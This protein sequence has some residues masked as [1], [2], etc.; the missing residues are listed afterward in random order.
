ML[1]C[2]NIF[3]AVFIPSKILHDALILSNEVENISFLRE[4]A[5]VAFR[6]LFDD[7]LVGL[8]NICQYCHLSETPFN[9]DNEGVEDG[10]DG[11]ARLLTFAF[12]AVIRGSS[13][14][15]KA[16]PLRS[17]ASFKS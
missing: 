9:R 10:K 6:E 16:D 5:L 4:T 12:A 8:G 17:R 3:F 1:A 13:P 2:F 11:L 14:K 15:A 7:E